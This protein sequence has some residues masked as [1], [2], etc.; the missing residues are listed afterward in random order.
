MNHREKSEDISECHGYFSAYGVEP[1]DDEIRQ[2]RRVNGSDGWYYTDRLNDQLFA[3][4]SW[5]DH[6]EFPTII[7]DLIGSRCGRQVRAGT[8]VQNGTKVAKFTKVTKLPWDRSKPRD[9]K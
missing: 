1:E 3:S 2:N 5:P 9:P 4:T 6:D 7:G 8:V